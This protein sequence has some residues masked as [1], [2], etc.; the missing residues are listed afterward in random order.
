MPNI[1]ITISTPTLVGSD[2][3]KTR[4]RL[5]GGAWSSYVNRTNAAFTLTGLAAGQYE[6]EVILVKDNVECPAIIKPFTVVQDFTCTT[7]TPVIVQNGSLFN[8]Q[9]SYS[10]AATP[11]CG[12]HIHILGTQNNKIVNYASLPT[13]PLLIP[14]INEPFQLKIIADLCNGNSKECLN[15]DVPS[16][17][18]A[19]T[20]MTITGTSISIDKTYPGYVGFIIRFTYTQSTPP[21]TG[22][23]LKVTQKNVLNGAPPGTVS[24]P[25][26]SLPIPSGNGSIDVSILGNS[27]VFASKYDFDWL[28][29][30]ACGTSHTGTISR[31]L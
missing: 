7:F 16:I 14:V 2:Y 15:T 23:T 13:S 22:L 20:P 19:C 30:D 27:N 5:I 18:P 28:I 11:N 24:Y 26:G 6:L 10:G 1:T 29:V 12:Y 8:L 31:Q 21:T 3:F 9:I 17:T 25:N 4:Y